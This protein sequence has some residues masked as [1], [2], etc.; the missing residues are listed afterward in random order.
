MFPF[1]SSIWFNIYSLL[2]SK[3]LNEFKIRRYYFLSSI[4]IVI[5]SN[6]SIKISS[7]SFKNL[8]FIPKAYLSQKIWL[9]AWFLAINWIYAK[10]ILINQ[11]CR[12]SKLVNFINFNPSWATFSLINV[13][14]CISYHILLYISNFFILKTLHVPLNNV[15]STVTFQVLTTNMRLVG[16]VI[17]WLSNRT[18]LESLINTFFALWRTEISKLRNLK[19]YLLGRISSE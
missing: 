17:R 16:V 3:W 13:T 19:I 7:V 8:D 10:I 6:S 18:R 12:Y 1:S 2:W 14:F 9:I 4:F 11:T 5:W 15:R